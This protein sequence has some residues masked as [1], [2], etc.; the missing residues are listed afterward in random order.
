MRS[1]PAGETA[2]YIPSVDTSYSFWFRGR[3]VTITRIEESQPY[4]G[5]SHKLNI[6][7]LF[8]GKPLVDE[9]L[10]QAWDTFATSQENTV[11][12]FKV[13]R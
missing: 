7:V 13:D 3:W 2:D 12:I 8:G 1:I 5:R 9:I 10:R 4:G 6:K 11:S